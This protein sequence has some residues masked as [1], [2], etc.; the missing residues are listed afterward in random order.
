[1][2]GMIVELPNVSGWD[3]TRAPA[4]P[5]TIR[6]LGILKTVPIRRTRAWAPELQDLQDWIGRLNNPVTLSAL[7][8]INEWIIR[9]R[10][11]EV[12]MVPTPER[13]LDI[14]GD[15][16]RLDQLRGGEAAL[17]SSRLSLERLGAYVAPLPLIYQQG[18]RPGPILVVENLASYE[19]FRHWN[20]DAL[21]GRPFG[22]VVWG[23]GN[24]ILALTSGLLECVGRLHCDQVLYVGD[25]DP[26]GL[27]FLADLCE[28]GRSINLSV[29][30][31][32]AA[33]RFLLDNGLRVPFERTREVR[34]ADLT[35]H[36]PEAMGEEIAL[37]LRA[38]HRIAQEA[39]GTEALYRAGGEIF[40]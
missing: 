5:K 8:A 40:R 23:E 10:G 3:R 27:I 1:M 36:L 26:E 39:L 19:S 2:D 16:K 22:A 20:A 37:L 9:R 32:L 14:F 4:L 17:F 33:Y 15:E 13:S 12:R 38:G 21:S 7:E 18:E 30:P 28:W 25:L 34:L 31:H 11:R 35:D 24:K 6:V 29:R